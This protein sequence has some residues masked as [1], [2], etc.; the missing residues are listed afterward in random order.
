MG[1]P[2]TSLDASDLHRLA[3]LP[4]DEIAL[5]LENDIQPAT[6]RLRPELQAALEALRGTGALGAQVSGSGPTLFGIFESREAAD[7]AAE[8]IP[9]ALAT[10]VASG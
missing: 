10:A 5:R 2:R 6:L 3:E 7:A 4:V 9:G 8:S 1:L